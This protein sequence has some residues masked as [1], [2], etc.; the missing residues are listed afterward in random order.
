MQMGD[1]ETD[2]AEALQWIPAGRGPDV[3][4]HLLT[5]VRP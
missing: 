3:C 5:L 2:V 1:E 4:G